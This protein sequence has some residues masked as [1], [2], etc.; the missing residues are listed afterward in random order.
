MSFC[1]KIFQTIF[2]ALMNSCH[3]LTELT[4]THSSKIEPAA[5]LPYILDMLKLTRLQKQRKIGTGG[6]SINE[7]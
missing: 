6:N 1:R 7:I 5:I 4:L 2:I 3:I